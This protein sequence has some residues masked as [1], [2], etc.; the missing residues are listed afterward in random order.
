[1]EYIFSIDLTNDEF[2]INDEKISMIYLE[3]SCLIYIGDTQSKL[4]TLLSD[5]S[6]YTFIKE[7]LKVSIPFNQN[8]EPHYALRCQEFLDEL[9]AQSK[10]EFYKKFDTVSVLGNTEDIVNYLN[11][12]PELK[13]KNIFYKAQKGPFEISDTGLQEALNVYNEIK[14]ATGCEILI[15]FE[16]N[17]K[18]S[19]IEDVK[20]V[21]DIINNLVT[22]IK[23]LNLSPLET[24]LYVYDIVRGREY[25]EEDANESY[26]KSRDLIS[27]LL[28]DKIVCVGFINLFNIILKK[29]GI[30]CDRFQVFSVEANEDDH[31]ESLVYLKDHKYNIE[32]L[33]IFDPTAE[34]KEGDNSYLSSYFYF[35]KTSEEMQPFYRREGMYPH[36]KYLTKKAMSELESSLPSEINGYEMNEYHLI[37]GINSILN[38]IDE[39]RLAFLKRYSKEELMAIF[40]KI[41]HFFNC[42]LPIETFIQAFLHVRTLE[43]YLHP[44]IFPFAKNT[45]REATFTNSYYKI[46]LSIEEQ[47][48]LKVLGIKISSVIRNKTNEYVDRLIDERKILGIKLSR[49]L[50]N[51]LNNN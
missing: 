43:Y 39:E 30:C 10:E 42:P 47:K 6:L 32:G 31:V 27:V 44:E 26:T 29:L 38:L 19:K 35:A 15:F 51:K 8:Y 37:E 50:R 3:D 34:C 7:D 21:L 1:M 9:N 18:P 14:E 24:T 46:P 33:Y 5:D 2:D 20:K 12:N 40:E 17:D 23:S 36:F 41:Y 22:E 11:A 16:G 49:Q 13:K 45:I 28:G 48:I 25:K 4:S